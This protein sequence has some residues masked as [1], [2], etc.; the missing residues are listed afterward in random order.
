MN[1]QKSVHVIG[2]AAEQHGH[3]RFRQQLFQNVGLFVQGFQGFFL[4][5][6]N[7]AE[8]L[9]HFLIAGAKFTETGDFRFHTALFPEYGGHFFL[10]GPGIGPGNDLFYFLK[11][12]LPRGQVKDAPRGN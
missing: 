2:L 6:G 3:F 4:A 10:I 9:L 8:P 11:A 12:R 7:K 1:I 5:L